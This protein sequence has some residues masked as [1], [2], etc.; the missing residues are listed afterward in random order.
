MHKNV[1]RDLD[2]EAAVTNTWK[3]NAE[4]SGVD[5][6]TAV[7]IFQ[8]I[9]ATSIRMQELQIQGTLAACKEKEAS[10]KQSGNSAPHIICT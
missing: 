4:V 2:R 9:L 3:Q 5:P 8:M 1:T 10:A 7:A 6:A